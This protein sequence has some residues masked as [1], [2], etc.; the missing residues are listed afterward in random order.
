MFL[1]TFFPISTASMNTLFPTLQP[2][3]KRPVE[4]V[5]GQ[6]A[7][8]PFPLLLDLVQEDIGRLPAPSSALGGW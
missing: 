2:H 7:D 1:L 3:L 5:F 6:S 8:D 4:V